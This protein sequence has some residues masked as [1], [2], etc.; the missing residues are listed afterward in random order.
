MKKIRK[1]WKKIKKNERNIN[2]KNIEIT[3]LETEKFLEENFG[4]I[5]LKLLKMDMK[6]Y[7]NIKK[8]L[9]NLFNFA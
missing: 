6:A 4:H 8:K 5:K 7:Q 3:K 9:S 2:L 1:N